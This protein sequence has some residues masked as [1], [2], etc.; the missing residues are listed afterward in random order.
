MNT[1]LNFFNQAIKRNG[2]ECTIH[3][4]TFMA[5]FKEISDNKTSIDSKYLLTE[6]DLN[7]GDII[8]YDSNKYFVITKNENINNV[9][10]VY[11]IQKEF[12]T[13]NLAVGT[14]LYKK[15]V[16]FNGSNTAI[17][18]N[19]YINLLNGHITLLVQNNSITN[20]IDLQSRFIKFNHAWKI[21]SIDK[22]KEGLLT[23]IGDLDTIAEG[24]DLINEIPNGGHMAVTNINV[25]PNSIS[26]QPLETQQLTVTVDVEGTLVE[27][28]TI[29]YSSDNESI[30][31]IS[32]TGLVTCIVSGNCNIIVTYKDADGNITTTEV[33]FSAVV[34]KTFKVTVPTNYYSQISSYGAY[35]IFEGDPAQ[36][37]TFYAMQGETQTSDTFTLNYS[38]VGDEYTI[39]N[40]TGNSFDI[41]DNFA[42][43][44]DNL[45]ITC[46]DNQDGSV[47]G[48]ITIDIRGAF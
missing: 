37:F 40:V 36:H 5:I 11:T 14:A 33:P 38:Y 2:K 16:I 25:T 34:A 26:L 41:T 24:D 21:T 46:T 31:T 42:Y 35:R 20:Q 4:N 23:I 48:T 43:Y 19:T 8:T 12:Q 29:T 7:Q 32:N 22:S 9:Y 15:D 3:S 17:D 6:Y 45:Y 44:D 27:N 39:S 10:N 1:L 13:V 28:P 18:Y 30:A 47:A